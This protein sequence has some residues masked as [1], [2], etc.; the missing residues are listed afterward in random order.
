M[1]LAAGPRRVI[2]KHSGTCR[3]SFVRCQ[4]Q[5]RSIT[6]ISRSVE[7]AIGTVYG[8]PAIVKTGCQSLMT[9]LL[10]SENLLDKIKVA[11]DRAF[12]SCFA[13]TGFLHR[14]ILYAAEVI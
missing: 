1:G 12:V 3:N 11:L 9:V 14:A 13:F 7:H 4:W 2:K 5:F 6:G 10:I 8:K